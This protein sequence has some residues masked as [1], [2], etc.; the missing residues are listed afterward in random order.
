MPQDICRKYGQDLFFQEICDEVKQNRAQ[1]RP[2]KAMNESGLPRR[3]QLNQP[4]GQGH[5]NAFRFKV[6]QIGR[7]HV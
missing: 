7:A 2:L 5:L 6:D 4:C 3:I 1:T